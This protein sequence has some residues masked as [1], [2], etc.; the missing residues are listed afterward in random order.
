MKNSEVRVLEMLIRVRQFGLT[1]AASFP[2]GSRGRELCAL[3]GEAVSD[4]EG[5][6]AT[7]ATHARAVKE[8]TTEK[9]AASD[10]LREGMEAIART[11]GSMARSAPGLRDKFRLPSNRSGQEWLAAAR[12]FAAEAEPLKGEFVSRGM[13]ADFLEEFKT[14]IRAVEQT[15][16]VRAQRSAARVSATAAVAEAAE[17]GREAARELD[18]VVRNVFRNDHVT[19]A[20]WESASRVERAAR[21]AEKEAPAPETAKV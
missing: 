7:Q 1:R 5:L 10:A 3:V 16:D 2:E 15:V 14:R 13:G 12:S 8:Q 4:I 11:A 17:R 6:S 18:A 9:K 21:R 20:E 19:L